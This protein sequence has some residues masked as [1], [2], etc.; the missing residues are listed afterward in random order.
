MSLR[1]Q[2]V[3]GIKWVSSAQ[4][5]QQAVQF[6]TSIV[7]ARLLGPS[8]FGL[9]AMAL[10]VSGF[11]SVFRDLGTSAAVIQH[12]DPSQ[13]LLSSI[14]WANALF[15]LLSMVALY[16]I[17]PLAAV[18]YREPRVIPILRAL[19]LV[20]LVSGVSI[21]QKAL[22]EQRLA[23]RAIAL[24]ET[25][26]MMAGSAVAIVSAL[27]GAGVWSLVFKSMVD[28]LLGTLLLWGFSGYHPRMTFDWK[29][30]KTVRSYSLNLTGF[31]ILNYFL[32]NADYLLI[33][34]HLGARDL[35]F[36]TLAYRIMLFPLQNISFVIGRVMFPVFAQL[37]D[38]NERFQ[39]GYLDVVKVIA[40]VSF[41]MML[42]LMALSEPFVLTVYGETWNPVIV[43]LLILAPVGLLQSIVT[44]V[45]SIYQAKGRTDWMFR[46]GIGSGVLI[47]GAFIIGIQWGLTGI[48]AAYAMVTLLIAYPNFAIPFRLI[49]L[50]FPRLVTALVRPLACSLIMYAFILALKAA[51]Q[52]H[53]PHSGVLAVCI[54]VGSLVYLLAALLMNRRSMRLILETCGINPSL[55]VPVLARVS[56]TVTGRV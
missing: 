38:Q 8:D 56:R 32:R 5:G 46:W 35:G 18:Y 48:A 10:V 41:P 6:A 49:D 24:I 25:S 34:R 29:E 44:T 27:L 20:C 43:L 13:G 21:L 9:L 51:V 23:F 31:N 12:K 7:L 53:L 17:A 14:F 33:G 37:R 45:G 19:S 55:L 50:K 15:G 30:L 2:A 40:L 52:A 1:K 47:V 36:Y 22:L 11:L 28:A 42:G 3:S 4:V 39:R 16:A 54:P 26:A